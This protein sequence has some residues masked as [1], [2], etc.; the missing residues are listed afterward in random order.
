MLAMMPTTAAL[1]PPSIV[2]R[3]GLVPKRTYAHA[4]TSTQVNPGSTN[5]T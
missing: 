2:A 3:S 1:K 4:S 5:P